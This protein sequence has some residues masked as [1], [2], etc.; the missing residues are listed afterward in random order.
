MSNVLHT[1][2][3]LADPR[4]REGC[5]ARRRCRRPSGK[6]CGAAVPVTTLHATAV[7]SASEVSVG[8]D[9]GSLRSGCLT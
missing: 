4:R 3:Y 1:S 8:L 9:A 7:R 2:F 5:R 6:P